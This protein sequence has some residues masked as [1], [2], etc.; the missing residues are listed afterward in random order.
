VLADFGSGQ[1]FWSLIWFFLFFAYI[2]ILITILMDLFRDH[3]LS[4]WA[5]AIW[6]I[7]LLFVP[8]ITML[9]YLIARGGGMA[10]RA[11]KQAQRQ[12]QAMNE[13]IRQTAASVGTGSSPADQIAQAQKLLEAGTITQAEFDALKAK[14][15]S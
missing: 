15:L 3:E 12:Q 8:L 11:M 6:I 13:Y 10:E 1:V 7:A 4:G 2:W 9:V 5:K 14:A